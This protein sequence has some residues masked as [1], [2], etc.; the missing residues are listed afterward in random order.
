MKLKHIIMGTSLRA[1]LTWS[2][3]EP[4]RPVFFKPYKSPSDV[5]FRTTSIGTDSLFFTVGTAYYALVAGFE[6]LKSIANLITLDFI[7]AKEN[8]VDARDALIGALILFVGVIASPFINLV[9]LIGGGVT[10]LMQNEEEEEQLEAT[11]ANNS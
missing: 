2:D 8:I 3:N 10:S 7:A 4:L 1:T 11:L 9:D 5:F 6:F